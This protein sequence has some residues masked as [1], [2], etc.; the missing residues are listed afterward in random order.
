MCRSRWRTSTRPPSLNSLPF[1]IV[2]DENGKVV[3]A[4]VDQGL[5]HGVDEAVL[6]VIETW[7]FYPA[8]RADK[9][10]ASKQQLLFHF[11]RA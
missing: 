9:P 8:T 1:D 6:A 2:I 5:G 11:E 3:D 4:Q 10:V 7:T